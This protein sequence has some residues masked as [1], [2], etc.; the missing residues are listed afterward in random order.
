MKKETDFYTTIA[1][2][3]EE[4]IYKE[5]NSKFI[6]QVF[7][8]G[9]EVQVKPILDGL[10][11]KYPQSNHICY[12]WQLGIDKI[13]H[14]AN[15]DGEPSNSAGM[16]IYGQIQSFGITN[17][18]VTV[19]RFFGGTKLGVGGLISAYRTSAK[20]ALESAAIVQK[21]I[22]V[23]FIV[24]FPYEHID[25]VMRTIKKHQISILDQKMELDCQI[26]VSILKSKSKTV[27]DLFA[28]NPKISIKPI[29]H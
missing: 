1:K 4:P 7:P 9:A 28:S 18:L 20:L 3:S 12:A 15:D 19:T 17:A 11:Q 16:P 27:F 6:S 25:K 8:I 22:E 29:P 10:R 2:I 5:R 24:K 13:V 23:D 14:R 26:Q 21:P